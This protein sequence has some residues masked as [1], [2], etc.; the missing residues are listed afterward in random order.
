M[1]PLQG[2]GVEGAAWQTAYEDGV[3]KQLNAISKGASV[4]LKTTGSATS[5]L[6][7]SRVISALDVISSC[8]SPFR[9]RYRTQSTSPKDQ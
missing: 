4:I 3:N 8:P 2:L 7:T 9:L 5:L 1:F 6:Q